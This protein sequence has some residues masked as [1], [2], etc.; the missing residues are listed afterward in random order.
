[1]KKIIITEAQKK[2]MEDYQQMESGRNEAFHFYSPIS[3]SNIDF[4]NHNNVWEAIDNT[5]LF[6]DWTM[7]VITDETGYEIKTKV[8]NMVG[9]I[10]IGNYDT[11]E[12]KTYNIDK[13]WQIIQEDT[14]TET[15]VKSDSI[16][17]HVSFESKTIKL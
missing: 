1:M 12:T 5:K 9:E 16:N 2:L 6:M 15:S 8:N 17:I 10:V 3:P 4:D 13:S 7:V 14:F 11:K